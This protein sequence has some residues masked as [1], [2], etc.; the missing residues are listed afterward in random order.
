M[1]QPGLSLVGLYAW[2]VTMAFGATL[3][4]AVYASRI[5]TDS[6][7]ILAGVGDF[8]LGVAALSVLFA[9]A[10]IAASWELKPAR[11]LLVASLVVVVI[12][13]LT[14]ALL[15]ETIRD[16]ERALGLRVGPWVRLGESGL[17]S[18]LAFIGLR[19]FWRNL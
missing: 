8:L 14:P 7:L 19:A 18:I 4:D 11:Y 10:A 17:A 9:L 1:R 3:L 2:T 16:A 6:P 13:L 12:G 5:A 15:S